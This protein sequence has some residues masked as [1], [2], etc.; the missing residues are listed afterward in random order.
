[1]LTP[2]PELP[3]PTHSGR[4]ELGACDLALEYGELVTEHEDLGVLGRGVHPT[5][6]K[7]FGNAAD[8][9]VDEA[10]RHGL[11]ASLPQSWLVK[12]TMG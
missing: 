4:P 5:D 6:P 1:M 9:T 3:L 2:R 7:Q 11:G 8:K 10:E 12:P